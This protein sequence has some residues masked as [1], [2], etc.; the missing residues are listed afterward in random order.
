MSEV[1]TEATTEVEQPVKRGRGRPRKVRPEEEAAKQE[2][3]RPP[4]VP[5]GGF[6]DILTLQNTDPNYHYH[7]ALD[8]SEKGT[9][10]A[11]CMQAGYEFVRP[12][13]GVVVGEASVF[14]TEGV[15][16]VLR[17]PGGGG[18]FHYL[19]KLPIEFF[20]EDMDRHQERV[21]MTEQSIKNQGKNDSFYGDV[22]I[23]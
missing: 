7:W 1:K 4:R 22:R 13:E 16:S 14:K 10:I 12:E 15:G 8:M 3:Q 18:M 20:K 9:Q 6:R 5:L 21:D 19:L 23:G 17:V 11:R 2:A